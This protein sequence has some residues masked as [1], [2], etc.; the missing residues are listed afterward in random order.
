MIHYASRDRAFSDAL[1]ESHAS[2]KALPESGE[3]ANAFAAL[4]QYGSL[5]L[6]DPDSPAPDYPPYTN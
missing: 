6:T 2:G 3:S 5:A 4:A 1:C